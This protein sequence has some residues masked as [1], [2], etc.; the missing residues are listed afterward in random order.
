MPPH[1]REQIPP[2]SVCRCPYPGNPG[3]THKE[4]FVKWLTLSN[5]V[6]KN[7]FPSL[8]HTM[9]VPLTREAPGKDSTS[10]PHLPSILLQRT[11][12]ST[13]LNGEGKEKE[14]R[15]RS[16]C[17]VVREVLATIWSWGGQGQSHKDFSPLINI[18]NAPIMCAVVREALAS[19]PAPS[20]STSRHRLLHR[21]PSG[22]GDGRGRS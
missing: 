16:L 1:S 3:R 5:S 11:M 15:P 2:R 12:I 7:S 9:F 13:D 21:P 6:N 8:H 4:Q 19:R 22:H 17:V 20:D 18:L 10:Q 14:I